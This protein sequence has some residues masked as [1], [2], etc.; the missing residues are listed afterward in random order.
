MNWVKELVY[1]LNQKIVRWGIGLN[2][3]LI[4][5]F[6]ICKDVLNKIDNRSRF[7]FLP[8]QY[9]Q[10]TVKLDW[11]YYIKICKGWSVVFLIFFPADILPRIFVFHIFIPTKTCKHIKHLLCW[12]LQDLNQILLSFG[13]RTTWIYTLTRRTVVLIEV[14]WIEL[15][16][17]QQSVTFN[18][19]RFL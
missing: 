3:G 8:K 2:R 15:W 19:H 16:R 9:I 14:W 18:S 7:E 13:A 12:S 11:T 1:L 4:S 5:V 6:T 10:E 17:R